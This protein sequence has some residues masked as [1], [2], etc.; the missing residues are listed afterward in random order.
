MLEE[1]LT[2]IKYSCLAENPQAIIL[3]DFIQDRFLLNDL[4][5]VVVKKVLNHAIFS[6]E[7][8]YRLRSKQLLLYIRRK[9]GFRK[10]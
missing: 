5:K 10:N 8:Q 7:N 1:H 2:K 6:K 9:G 3:F 4:Q